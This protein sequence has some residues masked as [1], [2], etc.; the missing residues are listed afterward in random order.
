MP[1][2]V[3]PSEVGVHG[4]AYTNVLD[5]TF[6]PCLQL[7][8]EDRGLLWASVLATLIMGVGWESLE[9]RAEL[10][11]VNSVHLE[12]LRR[13]DLEVGLS[14]GKTTLI[15]P[16]GGIEQNGVALSLGKHNIVIHEAADRLAKRLGQ[17]YVAPVV[18][19]VPNGAIDPPSGHMQ[20]VGS[21]SIT[22]AAYRAYLLDIAR[23]AIHQGF[24]T[25]LFMHAHGLSAESE[26]RV[27]DEINTTLP[28]AGVRAIVLDAY[29]DETELRQELDRWGLTEPWV[30]HHAGLIDTSELEAIDPESIWIR[31]LG[32]S[33]PGQDGFS[34]LAS[35]ALGDW[36]LNQRINAAQAEFYS[37]SP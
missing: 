5:L 11:R 4:L 17:T 15:I 14:Q 26:H 28:I 22:E 29:Y 25:L 37:K 3:S 19:Y 9:I 35:P 32:L 10:R 31:S 30:G 18:P 24:K 1:A 2:A 8:G 12:A 34:F 21:F 23:S 33:D 7:L 6:K 27:A 16:T 13:E 36:I 20:F